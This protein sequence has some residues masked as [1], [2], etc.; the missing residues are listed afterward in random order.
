MSSA[1]ALRCSAATSIPVQLC[2]M[3]NTTTLPTGSKATERVKW[4]LSNEVASYHYL[5]QMDTAGLA[6]HRPPP[7]FQSEGRSGPGQGAG[8]GLVAGGRPASVASMSDDGLSVSSRHSSAHDLSFNLGA[9]QGQ[10]GEGGGEPGSPATSFRVAPVGIAAG[11]TAG[12]A[13]PSGPG[14]SSAVQDLMTTPA[15][16]VS[17]H[18]VCRVSDRL[19]KA[20]RSRPAAPSFWSSQPSSS[21][22]SILSF[23]SPCHCRNKTWP[24]SLR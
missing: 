7:S 9:E 16:V 21:N 22:H 18:S 23:P 24:A 5:Y 20:F 2:L 8:A 13:T 3:F 4:G 12:E 17:T 14:A 15:A 11:A 6:H 1:D 10:Q 19:S